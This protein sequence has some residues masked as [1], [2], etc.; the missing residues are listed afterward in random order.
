MNNNAFVPITTGNEIYGWKIISHIDL[1]T[2]NVVA[3]IGFISEFFAAVKDVLGGRSKTYQKQ[4]SAICKDA[5]ESIRDEA[6]KAGGNAVI[7]L[8]MDYDQISSQGKSMLMVS[9]T[10]TAVYAELVSE[11]AAA[12][13]RRLNKQSLPVEG[14]WACRCG[15]ENPREN[16]SCLKCMRSANAII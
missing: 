14:S 11:E 4:L 10:G 13:C 9:A 2:S 15:Q 3:G 1:V 12:L 16:K 7:G 6:I 5:L 8:K